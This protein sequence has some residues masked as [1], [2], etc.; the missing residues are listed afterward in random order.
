ML[1]WGLSPGLVLSEKDR[2]LCLVGGK[3][4]EGC[5]DLVNRLIVLLVSKGRCNI[6][7]LARDLGTRWKLV[8]GA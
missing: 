5:L 3:V 1:E 8:M 4:K 7:P 6:K 2:V